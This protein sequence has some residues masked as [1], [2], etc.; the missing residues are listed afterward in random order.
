MENAARGASSM[1]RA[2]KMLDRGEIPPAALVGAT[3][4][5]SWERCLG[6]GLVPFGRLNTEDRIS[7]SRLKETLERRREL[8]TRARPVMDYLY[9]Q[10]RGSGSMV[11][12]AD[13]QGVLI[14]A[15]GD[16]D[17]VERASRV[18]LKPGASW[19]ETSRGTNAIGTAIVEGTAVLVHGAEHF[20]EHNRFLTCAAA[21]VTGSDGRILGVID[22]SG[23]HR[24]RHPHTSGLVSAASHMIENRLFELHHENHMRLRLHPQAEG[25]GTLA[26]GLVALAEDGRIAGANHAARVLL[27]LRAEDIG[28]K[29]IGAVLSLDMPSLCDLAQRRSG[30]VEPTMTRAGRPLCLRIEPGSRIAPA[31]RRETPREL[32]LRD[33]LADLDTGDETMKLVIER[34]RKVAGKPIPI[35]LQGE[36]GAGKERVSA[37]IHASGPRKN[38][39]FIAVNCAALPEHLIESELFGYAPGAFT[40]ARREGSPGRIREA[41]GGTLFLDE[42]GDMPLSL[43]SRLLRVLQERE[44]VPLGGGKPA[45]VDFALI[46][47]SHK[48][49]KAEVEGGRFRSDL[50]YRLNG[51]TLKLPAL[52][53]RT[54]FAA[55]VARMLV[56]FEPDKSLMLAPDVAAAFA[57]YRWPGNLRQL[58]NALLFACAVLD[59]GE[60]MIGWRHL[61]D[62]LIEDLQ[63]LD[64]SPASEGCDGSE[65]ASLRASSDSIIERAVHASE[66]NMSEAARR[67]GISRNTL[68]R[69]LKSCPRPRPKTRP[70]EPPLQ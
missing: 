48:P 49:L 47:A 3:V 28:R 34:A 26:E 23:H 4:S 8:L 22:V 19:H 29:A 16:A 20:L 5:R 15:L 25:I 66:G 18:A 2:R 59:P 50:Y 27:D 32:P 13:E 67:L 6:A 64:A 31:R 56:A 54:D 21:P 43:Q 36:S 62:D 52:R 11:V 41:N 37:A 14:E 57:R 30:R 51:L 10:V 58:S 61:P 68:Y 42:I 63:D 17:F 33:A 12:L 60:V 9:A 44:V 40:G 70:G 7:T 39:P 35:L 65:A 69:R 1:D 45:K 38:A 46:A 24:V 55:I 53:A